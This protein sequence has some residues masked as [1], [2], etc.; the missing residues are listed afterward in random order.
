ML[1]AILLQA[2][3]PG[4]YWAWLSTISVDAHDRLGS[5]NGWIRPDRRPFAISRD[6]P[7]AGEIIHPLNLNENG[8]ETTNIVPTATDDSGTRFGAT[9]RNLCR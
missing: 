8:F 6:T 9:C 5:A 4:Q 3:L 1:S 2:G 7:L